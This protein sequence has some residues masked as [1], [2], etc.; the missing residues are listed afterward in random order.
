M[1]RFSR[2]IIVLFFIFSLVSCSKQVVWPSS[3]LGRTIPTMEGAKGEIHYNDSDSLYITLQKITENQYANYLNECKAKGFTIDVK[4]NSIS[5]TAYNADGYKLELNFYSDGDM[6]IRVKAP[7][8]M[9]NFHWPNTP[10]SSLLPTPQS[11][12]GKIEYSSDNGFIAYV[13]NTTINDYN[14]YVE[15]IKTNGFTLDTNT[16]ENYYYANNNDG[17]RVTLKYEGFNTMFVRID[18][19][20]AE[21]NNNEDETDD[22][23]SGATQNQNLT[24]QNNQDFAKLVTLKDPSDSFV[25]LFATNYKGQIIEFDGCIL[26]MQYH[27]NYRTR[28]DILLGCGNYDTN[29]V[30]GPNFHLTNVNATDMQLNTLYP[31]E[32]IYVGKNVHIIAKVI[33]YNPNTTLFELDIISVTIR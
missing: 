7:I 21:D 16:G 28:Y 24:A 33:S 3:E 6:W 26:S 11:S 29:K 4:Q 18:A 1:K 14:S 25:E 17:Y 15:M 23:S 31:E 8:S 5:Y 20:S 2:A 10:I 9:S 22:S 12:F 27:E 19:P 13:G 32:I 30:L